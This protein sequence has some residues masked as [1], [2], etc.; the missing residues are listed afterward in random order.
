MEEFRCLYIS[1]FCCF[2]ELPF[3][4][5]CS[6]KVGGSILFQV[7]PFKIRMVWAKDTGRSWRPGIVV[8]LHPIQAGC[9]GESVINEGV[10]VL[11]PRED[12]GFHPDD[13]VKGD[14]EQGVDEVFLLSPARLCQHL[15]LSVNG[16][17]LKVI[18]TFA[19]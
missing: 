9:P 1:S 12:G 7:V 8:L 14:P 15:Q 2:P 16:H 13:F 4:F 11:H 17:Q 10:Y 19:R 3:E 18:S 5:N 6:F